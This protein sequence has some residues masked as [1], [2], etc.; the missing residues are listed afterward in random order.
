MADKIKYKCLG[1]EGRCG[2]DFEAPNWECFPGMKHVVEAKTY[3][4]ADAPHCDYKLDP[5]GLAFR[6]SKT[7]LHAIPE[8]HHTDENGKLIKSSHPPATFFQGRYE[9]SDPQYQFYLE[10]GSAKRSLCTKERWFEV[11]HTPIQKQHIKEG[12]LVQRERDLEKKLEE[13]NSLL[14]QAKAKTGKPELVGR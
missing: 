8:D 2:K 1:G 6:S 10:Y 3:Y 9:T 14:A 13:A 12:E 7:E 5:N 4:M 11:Y